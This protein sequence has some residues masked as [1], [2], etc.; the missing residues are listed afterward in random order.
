MSRRFAFASLVASRHN[1]AAV[2]RMYINKWGIVE[3]D[4]RYRYRDLAIVLISRVSSEICDTVIDQSDC[5]DSV[6]Q[7]YNLLHP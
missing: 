5:R 3:I 6:T 4:S 2:N 1:Y 7:S